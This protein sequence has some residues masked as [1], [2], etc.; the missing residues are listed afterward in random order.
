MVV[1]RGLL[2]MA[3]GALFF[4]LMGLM[5]K[6]V[7]DR[8]PAQEIVLVRALLNL[9]FTLYLIRRAGLAVWGNN[10][11][12]LLTRGVFGYIALSCFFFAIPRLPLADGMILINTYPLF[13]ALIAIP[14]LHERI[15]RAEGIALLAG[16]IGVTLISRPVWLFGAN[17]SNL[18]LL[19]VGV[20]LLG[21]MCAA[22]AYVVVRKLRTTEHPL[23]VV[24]Y[25]PLIA[26]P[27]SFPLVMA[28][29]VWPTATEWLLL[30]GIGITSQLGQIFITA[31]LHAERAGRASA[32]TYL[33]FVFALIWGWLVF[34][35]FPDVWRL[36]GS[37]IIIS[38]AL[39]LPWKRARR[40]MDKA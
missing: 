28:S 33:Q 21:A 8:I 31:G 14:I 39:M 37:A 20:T 17:T 6:L 10:Q 24:L 32:V 2:L 5:V 11:P 12:L 13:T 22:T 35:E 25:F 30:L 7:G 19:P 29:G 34:A 27:A 16:L 9:A 26:A 3:L 40:G 18:A 1:R 23:V 4:S 15:G 36:L 38:G